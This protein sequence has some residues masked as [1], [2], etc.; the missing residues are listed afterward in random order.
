MSLGLR[1]TPRNRRRRKRGSF[2]RGLLVFAALCGLGTLAYSTGSDLAEREVTEL[3]TQ[4]QRLRERIAELDHKSKRLRAATEAATQRERDWRTRYDRD[5][6][7]GDTQ[8]LVS[9]IESHLAAGAD[10]KRIELFLTAATRNV[11]CDESP[12]SKR[13]L[14]RTPLYQGPN[15]SVSFA[16]GTITATASGHPATDGEGKPEAWFDPAKNVTFSV[17]TISGEHHEIT[18][19]LPLHHSL[20]WAGDEYR[21]A[22]VNGES[23]GFVMVTADRCA[24]SVTD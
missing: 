2:F 1:Q 18:A 11:R 16:S 3:H 12:S 6:P 19:P 17:I 21:F 14:V 5:V 10:R 8:A 22:V 7:D 15:D 9:L 23:R 24:I 4:N 13:F 20:I